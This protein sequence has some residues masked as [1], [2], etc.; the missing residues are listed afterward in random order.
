MISNYIYVKEKEI[1]KEI[2]D[3]I[4]SFFET[5]KT[6]QKNGEAGE[7][8]NPSVKKT[9]D[10]GIDLYNIPISLTSSFSI[11]I[12]NIKKNV[13]IY[14]KYNN[15]NFNYEELLI[16]NVNIQKYIHHDYYYKSHH[17]FFVDKG[18]YRVY[19]FIYYLNDVECGGET[20]FYFM[21][22]KPECGKLLIF[23]SDPL[24]QHEGKMP[25]SNDKYI[26]TGWFYVTID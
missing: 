19:T 23:P 3:E 6:L 13:E 10:I 20:D 24:F 5:N 9:K 1:T 11:I 2:C 22:I 16:K 4:I 15:M 17:D 12:E 25:I 26:L 14:N 18:Y 21:N 7:K 8:Y